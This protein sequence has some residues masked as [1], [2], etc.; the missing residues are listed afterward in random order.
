M[1]VGFNSETR[2]CVHMCVVVCLNACVGMRA[3]CMNC[4][5][6]YMHMCGRVYVY[7]VDACANTCVRIYECMCA[8]IM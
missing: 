2:K 6:M 3:M 4:V 7:T 8:C 1:L 5:N